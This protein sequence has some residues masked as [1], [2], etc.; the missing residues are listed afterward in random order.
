MRGVSTAGDLVMNCPTLKS[1]PLKTW[2][3]NGS[4]SSGSSRLSSSCSKA[5]LM[6][7]WPTL[8]NYLWSP[9]RFYSQDLLNQR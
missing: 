1:S 5:G 6:A 9:T 4:S 2:L 3:A 7:A 8:E